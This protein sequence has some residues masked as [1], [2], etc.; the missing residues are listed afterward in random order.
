MNAVPPFMM[1]SW[2]WVLSRDVSLKPLITADE[3]S[4][5]NCAAVV[6]TA[7]EEEGRKVLL[8]ESCAELWVPA[9]VDFPAPVFR[10]STCSSC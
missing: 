3:T 6:S 7:A 4:C 1:T 2:S 10:Y 5:C 9:S 8:Q